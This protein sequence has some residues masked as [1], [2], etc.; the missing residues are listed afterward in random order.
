MTNFDEFL[1]TVLESS[2]GPGFHLYALVDHAGAPGLVSC[3]SAVPGTAWIS[4][5]ADST[6]EK[7]VDVAPLLLSLQAA[8][9]PWWLRWLHTACLESTSLAL[10]YSSADSQRLAQELKNR[11]NVMLPDKVPALLRYFDTRILES[12]RQVLEPDQCASFFGI[13]ARWIWLDRAGDVQNHVP[14]MLR[15]ATW[16]AYFA[17][18]E[19]QQN[20]MIDA[21]EADVLVQQ[22]QTYGLDLC[23]GYSRAALHVVA[24][25][26]SLRADELGIQEMPSR[27]LLALARLQ[28]GPNFMAKPE[29]V[30]FQA[31]MLHNKA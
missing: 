17:F 10:L 27:A 28:H 15:Y 30:E 23:A 2:P 8:A 29:W 20:A 26:A 25:E 9:T 3:L 4:L 24:Q 6:E 14:N 16:P 12:L 22:M 31:N 7:A 5:F 21:A 1:K 11:L 19:K 18:S 13:A